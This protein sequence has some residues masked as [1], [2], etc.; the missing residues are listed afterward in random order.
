M[1]RVLCIVLAFFAF[2]AGHWL[3]AMLFIILAVIAH[4]R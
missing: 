1:L 4:K 2:C 3:A